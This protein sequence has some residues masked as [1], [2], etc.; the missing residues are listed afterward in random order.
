MRGYHTEL[1]AVLRGRG[2]QNEA[3]AYTFDACFA[4]YVAGGVGR[5]VWFVPVLQAMGLPP[6]MNQ[7][8]HDQLAA[9]LHDHITDPSA[10]P[11]PR[12]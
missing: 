3:D 1:V 5:W 12:V 11:M 6:P 10:S 8:F 9:F 4:E 7:F 2:L